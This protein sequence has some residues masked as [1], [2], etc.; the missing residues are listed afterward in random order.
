LPNPTCNGATFPAALIRLSPAFD[1]PPLYQY[2]A[3][4]TADSKEHTM[5]KIDN[6]V[7][8]FTS[9]CACSQAI[10]ATYGEAFGIDQRTALKVAAGFAGGMRMGLTC[11]AATGAIMVLGLA[12]CT[13]D[14]Q[15]KTDRS[16][17]YEQVKEFEKRFQARCGAF[18][19]SALMGC[20]MSS[21]QGVEYA[22]KA[23]LFQSRCPQYV[24]AAAEI[25][26]EM[27]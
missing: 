27:L 17:T 23:G 7:S 22:S 19:C 24:R 6:A 16:K 18:A 13:V 5:S 21:P 9:G 12:C 3:L 4:D 11:G 10:L 14:G 20:D 15:G 26:E 8:L 25:L 2:H 1:T